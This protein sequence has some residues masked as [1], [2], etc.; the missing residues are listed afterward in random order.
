MKV[1]FYSERWGDFMGADPIAMCG[2]CREITAMFSLTACVGCINERYGVDINEK[3]DR[4]LS[5]KNKINDDWSPHCCCDDLCES[6][7]YLD[8]CLKKGHKVLIDP[9]W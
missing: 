2:N 8:G 1:I 6:L 7:E 5:N 9:Y 3:Q 4:I